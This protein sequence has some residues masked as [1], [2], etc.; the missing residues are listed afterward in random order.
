[1]AK[2]RIEKKDRPRVKA[3]CLRML[4]TAQID[5]EKLDLI[6]EFVDTY[7]RL[8]E[9]EEKIFEQ[10]LA[11]IAPDIESASGFSAV[12]LLDWMRSR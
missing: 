6:G 1:M 5:R 12:C 4:L 3:E 8:N 11:T 10:E 7:L 9:Q 2:M